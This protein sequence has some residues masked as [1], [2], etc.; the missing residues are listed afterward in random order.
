MPQRRLH[1]CLEQP[2]NENDLGE[3]FLE[4]LHKYIP[5]SGFPLILSETGFSA[6][7]YRCDSISEIQDPSAT[8]RKM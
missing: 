4:A 7:S 5:E 6:Q 8:S 3:E 2:N 1:L